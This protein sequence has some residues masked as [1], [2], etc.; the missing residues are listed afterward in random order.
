MLE[1]DDR[2][3]EFSAEALK[4]SEVQ[5]GPNEAEG[6]IERFSEPDSLLPVVAS[7]PERSQLGEGAG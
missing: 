5:A 4:A 1:Q 7:L 6:V 2:P 3:G